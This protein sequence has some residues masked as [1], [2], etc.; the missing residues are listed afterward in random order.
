[1]LPNNRVIDR[2]YG[3]TFFASVLLKV[4]VAAP[5]ELFPVNDIP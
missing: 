3:V 2:G 4:A 5:V 1:M